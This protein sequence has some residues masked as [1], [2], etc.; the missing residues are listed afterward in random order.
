[1]TELGYEAPQLLAPVAGTRRIYAVPMTRY[2]LKSICHSTPA[3]VIIK[4]TMGN[5]VRLVYNNWV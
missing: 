1:M 2:G 4:Y 3:S 5:G